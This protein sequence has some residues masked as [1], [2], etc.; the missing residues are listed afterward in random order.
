MLARQLK[1]NISWKILY[2]Y[3]LFTD[4]TKK[5]EE[6]HNTDTLHTTFSPQGW[7]AIDANSSVHSGFY[8]TTP[9]DPLSPNGEGFIQLDNKFL[10]S[11][12]ESDKR[13][14]RQ[15]PIWDIPSLPVV[16]DLA[17]EQMVD[18]NPCK[19]TDTLGYYNN[20]Y[21]TD[22]TEPT[23]LH[24]MLL[25]DQEDSLDIKL[26]AVTPSEVENN[27]VVTEYIINNDQGKGGVLEPTRV[28]GRGAGLSLNVTASMPW[29]NVSISTPD[30]VSYVE[31]LETEKCALPTLVCI[32]S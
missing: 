19:V 8:N 2:Y 11:D 4:P 17:S 1:I 5:T 28:Q 30:V 21:D 23:N 29:S 14:L 32:E 13:M 6:T 20:T 16:L 18:L 9:N 10:Y 15:D 25:I 27:L 31:Q 26:N 24:K 22:Y 3:I 7:D 12:I